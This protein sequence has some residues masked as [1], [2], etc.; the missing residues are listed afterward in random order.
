MTKPEEEKSREMVEC[1]KNFVDSTSSLNGVILSSA[2]SQ[3]MVELGKDRDYYNICDTRFFEAAMGLIEY[4]QDKI[5][6]YKKKH[7]A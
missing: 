5:V 7:G 3:L 6:E 2:Y 4:Y 1:I